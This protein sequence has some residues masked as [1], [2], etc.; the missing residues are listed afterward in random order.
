MKFFKSLVVGLV[1]FGL[2]NYV[3]A[4]FSTDI[5]D[6]FIKNN[7]KNIG[8]SN[9]EIKALKTIENAYKYSD[10]SKINS[11]FLSNE[12]LNEEQKHSV[13]QLG[14]FKIGDTNLGEL[15]E[16]LQS[17]ENRRSLIKDSFGVMDKTL[18]L[19]K[20]KEDTHNEEF[21]KNIN[22]SLQNISN[23]RQALNSS[24]SISETLKE[25]GESVVSTIEGGWSLSRAT[26]LNSKLLKGV[27]NIAKYKDISKLVGSA[28]IANYLLSAGKAIYKI[29]TDAASE[30][31]VGDLFS[32]V[33]SLTTLAPSILKDKGIGKGSK[34]A[35][36]MLEIEKIR[37]EVNSISKLSKINRKI[38][39]DSSN[40]AI[41]VLSAEMIDKVK[42]GVLSIVAELSNPDTVI[43]TSLSVSKIVIDSL[44]KRSSL[45]NKYTYRNTFKNFTKANEILD[46]S[47]VSAVKSNQILKN[48]LADVI[49]N[50]PNLETELGWKKAEKP[51][52]KK[53]SEE[54]KQAKKEKALKAKNEILAKNKEKQEAKQ[55]QENA[56]KLAEQTEEVAKLKKAVQ[57]AENLR[58]KNTKLSDEYEE[59]YIENEKNPTAKNQQKLRDK[60]LEL[61]KNARDFVAIRDEIISETGQNKSEIGFVN[62]H[63]HA[64]KN[65]KLDIKENPEL[66]QKNLSPQAEQ[67]LKIKLAKKRRAVNEKSREQLKIAEKFEA[68]NKVVNKLSSQ[69]N[70]KQREIE[71]YREQLSK[72]TNGE[73]GK[74]AIYLSK[75][76]LVKTIYD[77][78]NGNISMISNSDKQKLQIISKSK[79]FNNNWQSLFE[80]APR[81][82][83]AVSKRYDVN[84]G[85]SKDSAKMKKI[86]Q[87]AISQLQNQIFTLSGQIEIAEKERTEI[88][89]E[90]DIGA[91]QLDDLL[92]DVNDT[93][94]EKQEITGDKPFFGLSSFLVRDGSGSANLYEDNDVILTINSFSK[95]NQNTT[96]RVGDS[97]SYITPN[98]N[99]GS[100]D[101]FGSYEYVAWGQ[102]TSNNHKKVGTYENGSV[103]GQPY[104]HDIPN[105]GHWA[106][107][108]E[109]Y[110][111]P[112]QGQA[113]YTGEMRG[114]WINGSGN[115][116][117]GAMSGNINFAVNFAQNSISGDGNIKVNNSQIDTFSFTPVVFGE[118]FVHSDGTGYNAGAINLTHWFNTNNNQ[119]NTNALTTSSGTKMKLYG[120]LNGKG[121]KEIGGGFDYGDNNGSSFNEGSGVFRAKQ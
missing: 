16:S 10:S 39:S 94:K 71:R 86:L 55:K 30:D 23:A 96:V 2:N 6:D 114:D 107:G 108:Q 88:R 67:D 87:N 53:D 78:Y 22:N 89:I 73:S 72:F 120:S 101:H 37:K 61:D 65:A 28:E 85:A 4:S 20:L 103:A 27:K 81:L 56:K 63:N 118:N 47:L 97:K 117:I 32:T 82:Y 54:E 21:N 112:T 36:A 26:F 74:N 104:A 79:D 45:S 62:N 111:V 80:T 19:V 18:N 9:N 33:E 91:N 3:M 7:Q 29:E 57:T 121:G 98:I 42:I 100:G 50:S 31:I 44:S 8:I 11:S 38:L 119:N 52:A 105:G 15:V 106:L 35:K 25:Q 58:E 60:G 116:E 115:A 51:I 93:A 76:K 99:T 75:L 68:K 113:T 1:V 34:Y 83:E 40:S 92:N 14:E 95:D 66:L 70:S 84:N 64:T 5:A 24:R 13:K 12:F 77:R 17:Y 43:G 69:I 41:G 59:L 49:L 110:D 48:D 109:A 46:K 90:Y 102:W